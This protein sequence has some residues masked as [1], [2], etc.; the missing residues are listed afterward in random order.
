M[1]KHIKQF[2]VA[3]HIHVEAKEVPVENSFFHNCGSPGDFNELTIELGRDEMTEKS[4]VAPIIY[5]RHTKDGQ[6]LCRMMN[7]QAMIDFDPDLLQATMEMTVRE[8]NT[9]AYAFMMR[10]WNSLTRLHKLRTDNPMYIKHHSHRTESL[11]AYCEFGDGQRSFLRH[12]YGQVDDI[13]F[14]EP[15]K[16]DLEIPPHFIPGRLW[17]L[18]EGPVSQ[19]EPEEGEEE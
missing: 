4:Y 17:R 6:D 8:L 19:G 1:S 13:L 18:F 14:W 12:M 3:Q 5:I 9:T 2:P 10:C 15:E 16:E 7:V 11:M